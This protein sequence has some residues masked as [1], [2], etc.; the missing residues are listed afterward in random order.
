[1]NTTERLAMPPAA[2]DGS[3]A[4]RHAT[5]TIS[6]RLL[7][8]LDVT[9]NRVPI[10]LRGRK[11]RA[12]LSRLLLSAGHHIPTAVLIDDL[13]PDRSPTSPRRVVHAYV[14]EVR[15]ALKQG[16]TSIRFN[17]GGYVLSLDGDYLDLDRLQELFRSA[18]SARELGDWQGAAD[19]YAEALALWRDDPLTELS[20]TPFAD[21]EIRR[22]GNLRL[23]IVDSWAECGLALGQHQEVIEMLDFTDWS[24]RSER[25]AYLLM[26]ALY[27]AGRQEDALHRY[28]DLRDHLTTSLGVEPG[29]ELRNLHRT[30]LR[31]D[32]LLLG[33]HEETGR[34]ALR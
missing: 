24:I 28:F 19:Y 29:P 31:H 30:I 23:R 2:D 14:S 26:V 20:G 8:T 3:A 27:R 18:E 10:A 11:R 17:Q 9:M 34:P 13:W 22:L 5:G 12:L 15:Q 16:R 1:M 32:P 6:Y 33:E 4:A 25:L 21:A 7:G